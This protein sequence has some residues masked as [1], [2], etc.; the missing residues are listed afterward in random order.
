MQTFFRCTA[1]RREAAARAVQC[2]VRLA[3]R[4]GRRA[5]LRL[6]EQQ[7]LNFL[8]LLPACAREAAR[9]IIDYTTCAEQI[10]QQQANSTE[11]CDGLQSLPRTRTRSYCQLTSPP[12]QGPAFG[13]GCS[14]QG[15]PPSA[16]GQLRGSSAPSCEPA[17]GARAHG[18]TVAAAH[19]TVL[20]VVTNDRVHDVRVLPEAAR[21]VAS[22]QRQCGAPCRNVDTRSSHPA[23]PQLAI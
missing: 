2:S 12:W 7:P 9:S 20:L 3:R 23:W 18:R 15:R 19:G 8:G 1:G 16:P 5:A 10:V 21:D 17:R 13:R 14:E 22:H 11:V 4:H 6:F